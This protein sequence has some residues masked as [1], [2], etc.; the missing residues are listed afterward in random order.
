MTTTNRSIVIAVF[1]DEKQVQQ[2]IKDLQHAGF[3]NDQIRYSVSR[4]DGGIADDLVRMGIPKLEATYYNQE[5]E[6]GHI[7]VTVNTRDQQQQASTILMHNGGSDFNT[8]QGQATN[9]ASSASGAAVTTTEAMQEQKIL[10]RAEE[11]KSKTRWTQAGEVDI[12]KDVVSEQQTITVPVT[13]EDVVIEEHPV[14]GQVSNTP[15]A[16]DGEQTIRIPVNEEQVDVTKQTV[17]TG[18]VTVG[19]RQVQEQEQVSDTVRH[20][21]VH[22]DRQGEAPIHGTKTDPFHPSQADV[23]DLLRDVNR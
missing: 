10:L 7:V 5:F 19:K 6:Q 4:G 14:S 18:E 1:T 21:E 22:V 12:T 13:H 20:E 23:E 15:I 9:N 8:K 11:L 3:S 2:A 16:A 17:V